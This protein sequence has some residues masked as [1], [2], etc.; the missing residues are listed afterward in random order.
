MIRILSSFLLAFGLLAYTPLDASAGGSD[1]SRGH[2]GKRHGGKLHDG[3]R[4]R[5][6]GF[7]RAPSPAVPELDPSAA[8]AAL[9]LL[10]GGA[11]V[12]GGRR[13][14]AAAV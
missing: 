11:L 5:G 8:G 4:G 1:G 6:H 13:R 2:F 12:L 7:N 3:H 10:A 14:R 9:T